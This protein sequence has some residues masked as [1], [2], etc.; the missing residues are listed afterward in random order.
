[1]VSKSYRLLYD[2]AADRYPYLDN[3]HP[4]GP[5]WH[6]TSFYQ[7]HVKAGDHILDCGCNNGGLSKYFSEELNCEVTGFD[8]AYLNVERAK[9]NAPNSSFVS[10]D[11]EA[12]PFQ[13]KCFDVVIAGE[14]LEHVLD[15]D[16]TISEC[17]RV[18]KT[19]GILLTSTPIESEITTEHVRV[20]DV[21]LLKAALPAIQ[22]S[23]T[24]YSWMGKLVKEDNELDDFKN[25]GA[26]MEEDVTPYIKGVLNRPSLTTLINKRNLI[27][28]EVGVHTAENAFNILQNLDI[29]KLYLIDPYSTYTNWNWTETQ[30]HEREQV[31]HDRLKEYDN[32]IVWIKTDV[33]SALPE[34]KE[35]LDFI[36]LDGDHTKDALFSDI[37]TCFEIVKFNGLIAGHDYET[38]EV[39][40]V[41]DEMFKGTA[42]VQMDKILNV[43]DW[44]TH[45]TK[46][47]Q[48]MFA[49]YS[50]KPHAKKQMIYDCMMYFNEIELLEIR[51][52]TLDMVVDKFVIVE[53]PY[54]HSGK[55]K[56]LYLEEA[57]KE[58]RFKKF[59]SK[60]IYLCD[61][62]L[63]DSD[64][65]INENR[66]RK[67]II[68]GLTDIE[69]NDVVMVSDLDEIINPG[70]VS[71]LKKVNTPHHI[72][73]KFFYY[74][75]NLQMDH[76][77]SVAYACKGRHLKEFNNDM[78]ALRFHTVKPECPIILD[79]GWH[80]SYLGGADEII[81]KIEG[82]AHTENNIPK[83]KNKEYIENCL[84]TGNDLFGRDVSL[85]VMPLDIPMYVK[86]NIEKYKHL[87]AH[88]ADSEVV[89]PSIFEQDIVM[90]VF[91][92][93]T[94]YL[95]GLLE[96]IKKYLPNVQFIV[97]I[98][99]GGIN[100]N[101]E[102]LRQKFIATN[103]RFW[104]FLD[105][106]IKF[107]SSSILHK[108]V[109]DLIKN[110]F[111]AIGVYSTFDPSYKL[112][113]EELE[114]KE[115]SWIPGYF[116]M[117]D[118][119]AV[120]DIEPDLDL[121]DS[122]TSVDTSYCVS[123]K[124]KGHKIGI[125]PSVVYHYHK[126]VMFN[127]KIGTATNKYLRNKWGDFYFDTIRHINNIV[128]NIPNE[129]HSL[130]E[131]G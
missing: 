86:D 81:A 63:P 7:K 48:K 28:A 37:F 36:Y 58:E 15:L 42:F 117:V 68:N 71:K 93:R 112:K 12:I 18:L 95:K 114:C 30:N 115:V 4:D 65:W 26:I 94:M 82:L 52:N 25:K 124:A 99:D 3:F 17:L 23:N 74:Y 33:F 44:W 72:D 78:Q 38:D 64:S 13:S 10:A 116:M 11:V 75:F 27:G 66:Q 57:L 50:A 60:I 22:L 111:G 49:D 14:L 102:A 73:M 9:N 98:A 70:I 123:I 35:Q 21:E 103:K 54:T 126:K 90:G 122:N 67:F 69:D 32:K 56:P 5:H 61:N 59:L 119:R 45:N 46:N 110:R 88:D 120:G 118:R 121:P 41:V 85:K 100:E 79:G 40:V 91:T 34:I 83:F 108:A 104:V 130:E 62:T 43:S 2:M 129:D 55:P 1:M 107:L 84:V 101:M 39:K 96:S 92:H 8:I 87:I 106:D 16:V 89:L 19:G 20:L 128:G 125:S 80:F 29:K 53:S 105:D 51:L 47:S 6:R 109:F 131:E 76:N 97:H 113:L 127:E 77:A 31:A 24:K